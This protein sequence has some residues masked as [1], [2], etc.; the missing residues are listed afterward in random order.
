MRLSEAIRLG[1]M[2]KPQAFEGPSAVPL[3]YQTR[4]CALAAAADALGLRELNIW[5]RPW[6]WPWVNDEHR[7]RVCPVCTTDQLH[8][9]GVIAH[10]NDHHHWAREVIA[11]FV[12]TIEPAPASDAVGQPANDAPGDLTRAPQASSS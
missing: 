4:T 11:D 6:P 7:Q 3:K 2:L 5:F 12:A 1:A 8:P 10:L 9:A